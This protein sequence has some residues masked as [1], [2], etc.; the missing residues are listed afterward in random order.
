MKYGIS[1]NPPK[2]SKRDEPP[3]PDT[4]GQTP[5]SSH[6]IPERDEPPFSAD[7][8]TIIPKT[9]RRS[10]DHFAYRKFSADQ[11]TIIPKFMKDVNAQR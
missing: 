7:Q 10:T 5:H 6:E 11:Q 3:I 4:Y 1:T 8:Q 2:T 9:F